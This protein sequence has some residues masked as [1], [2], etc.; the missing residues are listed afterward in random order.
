MENL[1]RILAE[2]PFLAGLEPRYI[3]LITG[4]ASNIVFKP[5]QFVFREGDPADTFYI[6]RHGKVAIEWFVPQ[7]GAVSIETL[8]EGDVVGWSWMV[9][10]YQWRGDARAYDLTRAIAIDAKCL[11]DKCEKDHDLGYELMK[12][13][14]PLIAE[15]LNATRFQ[16]L[17]VYGNG[18]VK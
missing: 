17:D 16:L 9:A 4:C 11:R 3:S 7:K 10:P 15:T 2:H 14:V 5:G 8:Q 1:E 6:I 18:A 12:R 13:I